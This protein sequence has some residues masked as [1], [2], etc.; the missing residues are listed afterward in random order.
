VRTRLTLI[1]WERTT[2]SRDQ[3]VLPA[4]ETTLTD[5]LHCLAVTNDHISHDQPSLHTC[6][7]V[8]IFDP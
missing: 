7:P 4:D 8:R 2:T 5:S 3:A 6:N 1:G